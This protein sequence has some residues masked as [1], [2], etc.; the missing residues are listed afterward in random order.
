MSALRNGTIAVFRKGEGP[1]PPN[2]PLHSTST[3]DP[4]GQHTDWPSTLSQKASLREAGPSFELTTNSIENLTLETPLPRAAEFLRQN[5]HR[6]S[7]RK[8]DDLGENFTNMH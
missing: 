6:K 8:V 7:S 2:A 1:P 4:K 5:N 3:L